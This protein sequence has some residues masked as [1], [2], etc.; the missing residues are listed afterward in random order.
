MRKSY[1]RMVGFL[2]I[3]GFLGFLGFG[4]GRQPRT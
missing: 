4:F 1:F 3:L 2:G